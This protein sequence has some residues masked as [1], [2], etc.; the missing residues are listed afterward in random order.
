MSKNKSTVYLELGTFRYSGGHEVQFD[1]IN[2]TVIVRVSG[3]QPVTHKP[4]SWPNVQ[5]ASKVAKDYL[6]HELTR[7]QEFTPK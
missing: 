1:C 6:V 3:Y 2:K 4:I 7:L 5:S